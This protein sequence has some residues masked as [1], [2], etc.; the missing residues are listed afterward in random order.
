ML[1]YLFKYGLVERDT[2]RLMQKKKKNGQVQVHEKKMS[3]EKLMKKREKM[4]AMS[5]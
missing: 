1:E 3:N 5:Q 4:L 2:K